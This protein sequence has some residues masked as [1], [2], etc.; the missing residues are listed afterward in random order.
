MYKHLLALLFALFLITACTSQSTVYS[1]TPAL[2]AEI[3]RETAALVLPDGRIYCS[4]VWIDRDRLLTAAHCVRAS[5]MLQMFGI[6]PMF[7]A[8]EDA[9]P[10]LVVEVL[11]Y[12]VDHDLAL[13]RAPTKYLHGSAA[14][15]TFTPSKGEIVH[16]VGHPGAIPWAYVHGYVSAYLP[17]DFFG[18]QPGATGPFMQL[19]APIFK[20]HSGAAVFDANGNIV[21]IVSRASEKIP[22]VAIV[23]HL[24]TV[25]KF[26]NERP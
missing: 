17:E 19:S 5:Q 26:L 24:D 21:G 25:R 23:V 14:L 7:Q 9:K 11:K 3:S 20:G 12:D 10:E 16:V 2:V 8:S 1:P 13:L 4:A 22:D 18:S 6:E 15:A